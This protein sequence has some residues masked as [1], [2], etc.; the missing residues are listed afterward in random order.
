MFWKEA[1]LVPAD[2]DAETKA[3]VAVPRRRRASLAS[4]KGNRFYCQSTELACATQELRSRNVVCYLRELMAGEAELPAP[5]YVAWIGILNRLWRLVSSR[6]ALDRPTGNQ[7]QTENVELGLKPGEL[8]EVKGLDEIKRTLDAKSRNRG[9]S[10][11]PEMGLH[12]GKRYRVL[13]PIRKMIV[14]ETGK[15]LSLSNT[16]L[17]NGLTCEGICTWT[18]P[19]AVTFSGGNVGSNA[20]K[21]S[22]N[23]RESS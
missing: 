17:L 12:C 5:P 1:W 11:E 18:C 16:V 4:T 9:L 20:W 19:R 8:V 13:G 10:F 14:E 23:L 6:T 21:N 2:R 15:M 3:E 22:P 7:K